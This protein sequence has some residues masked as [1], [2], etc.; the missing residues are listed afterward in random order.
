MR[1]VIP[2]TAAA[3]LALAT[4]ALAQGQDT[5]PG[6]QA[7]AFLEQLEGEWSM[8]AE[9]IP[10][11]DQEPVRTEGRQVARLLGGHW[12]IAET[13]SLPDGR[14]FTSIL[15][16]GWDSA[17]GGIV[18]TWVDARQTHLW[19]YEGTL[20]DSGTALTLETEGPILGN[21][22]RTA[23]Y[24]EII[25]VEGPDHWVMRSLILGPDG[26]WFEFA[27]ADHRRHQREEEEAR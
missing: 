20:D 9:A 4:P 17:E 24:R 6:A 16:L 12:L 1:S 3:V 21:P 19:R 26:Q 22:T 2:L 27:R 7:T 18:G 14:P 23:E 10:G 25:E 15:T 5:D 13:H 8:T 11:P